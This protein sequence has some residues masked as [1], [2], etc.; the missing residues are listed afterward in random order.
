MD[1]RNGLYGKVKDLAAFFISKS[2]LKKILTTD[3]ID[4][5]I[6]SLNKYSGK[7]L[8]GKIRLAQDR[9]E[10]RGL[11][12]RVKEHKPKVVAEIG[13]WDGGTFYVW[14][15]INSEAKKVISIDLPDGRYGG[16]YNS[17]RIKFFKQFVCDRKNTSL[18][19]IRGDSKSESTISEL[20]KIL[21]KDKIDFLFIDGDHTYEGVKKD[22]EIYM[23]FMSHDGLVGFHDI[24]TLREEC[25]VHQFWK[26]IKSIYKFEEFITPGGKLMGNGLLYMN[27]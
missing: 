26:E 9:S 11:C 24:T 22:F 2:R 25:G 6:D 15:R 21:G 1:N 17:K 16:G 12:L 5:V 10:L 3:D 23:Q 4:A 20:K 14:T 19:F 7:G 18:H 13:T 8:Y 27:K